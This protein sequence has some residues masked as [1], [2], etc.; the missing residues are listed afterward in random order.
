MDDPSAYHTEIPPCPPGL[1]PLQTA[2]CDGRPVELRDGCNVVWRLVPVGRGVWTGTVGALPVL[3]LSPIELLVTVR[4][5]WDAM[6]EAMRERVRFYSRV[7]AVMSA[8]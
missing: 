4:Q 8:G 5:A 1:L 7:Q 2:I 3:A 6:P